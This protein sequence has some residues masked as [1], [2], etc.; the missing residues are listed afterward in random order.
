MMH[1]ENSSYKVTLTA[2]SHFD[3]E[4]DHPEYRY[5]LNPDNYQSDE[6]YVACRIEIRTQDT[7]Q[8]AALIGPIDTDFSD[9]AVLKEN[10]LYVLMGRSVTEIDLRSPDTCIFHQID[11]D[12]YTHG[13]FAHED[14]YLIYSAYAV[15]CLDSTFRELWIFSVDA[16]ITVFNMTDTRIELVDEDD[17]R[18]YIG[19]DGRRRN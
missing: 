18:H 11:P 12:G 3:L 5:V 14:Q 17:N 1:L 2:D 15:L 7:V 6:N 19:Y 16:P 8:T 4:K 9:L 13:I 10:T